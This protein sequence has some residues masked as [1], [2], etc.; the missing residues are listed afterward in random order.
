[1]A[2]RNMRRG[3]VGPKVGGGERLKSHSNCTK[4][5]CQLVHLGCSASYL[6]V[7]QQRQSLFLGSPSLPE[8][9]PH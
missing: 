2:F 6:W 3:E 1:M 7:I 5:S 4:D 9:L 8:R